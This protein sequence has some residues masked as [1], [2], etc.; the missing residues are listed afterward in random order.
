MIV[1]SFATVFAGTELAPIL[2]GCHRDGGL[3]FFKGRLRNLR[4]SHAVE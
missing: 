2:G 3:G 4:V 1:I